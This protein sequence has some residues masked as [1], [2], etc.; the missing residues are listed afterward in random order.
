MV[1]ADLAIL[2]V[3]QAHDRVGPADERREEAIDPPLGHAVVQLER[4]RTLDV[5]TRLD[6]VLRIEDLARKV[7]GRGRLHLDRHGHPEALLDGVRQHG[8]HH[9]RV[10]RRLGDKDLESVVLLAA[11]T[12]RFGGTLHDLA[13]LEL[14]ILAA[15]RLERQLTV[16]FHL[17]TLPLAH[18]ELLFEHRDRGRPVALG[19]ELVGHAPHGTSVPHQKGVVGKLGVHGM[20]LNELLTHGLELAVHRERV[21]DHLETRIDLWGVVLEVIASDV[22]V[23]RLWILQ[24]LLEHGDGLGIIGAREHDALVAF[25]HVRVVV[26]PA[27][28]DLV[29]PTREREGI[30]RAAVHASALDEA[31]IN[32]R[33]ADLGR[34]VR[35]VHVADS[36][37]G[38]IGNDILQDVVAQDLARLLPDVPFLLGSQLRWVRYLP[39]RVAH[40]V[41]HHVLLGEDLVSLVRAE[42]HGGGLEVD[43]D[44]DGIRCLS[45]HGRMSRAPL[46]LPKIIPPPPTGAMTDTMEIRGN[47]TPTTVF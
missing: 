7:E 25:G 32:Q 37:V 42:V 38:R 1:E 40:G 21:D 6:E 46:I 18:R 33:R 28:E 41:A 34:L 24:E 17:L 3:R 13:A 44:A 5:G 29:Q 12:P 2:V 45:A 43:L 26:E 16:A 30:R 4:P 19:G 14:R 36:L 9:R 20:V 22:L 27:R 10:A 8:L 39:R 23:E 11:M 47:S 31:G 35:D 15:E